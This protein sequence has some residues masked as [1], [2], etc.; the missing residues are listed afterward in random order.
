MC[1]SGA[2]WCARADA[3][4]DVPDLHVLD[5]VDD[6][7]DRLVLTVESDQ[8]EA[9]C[10]S[11]GVL[12]AS[13]GRRSRLLHDAPCFGRVT[14]VRWL[15]R[16]WRCREPLCPIGVFSETHQIAPPRSVL[17]VR[18]VRWATDALAHDD[19]T[20]SALAR[21]IGVLVSLVVYRRLQTAAFKSIQLAS[22]LAQVAR[23]GREVIDG[24]YTQPARLTNQTDDQDRAE[25]PAA[26]EDGWHEI[27][28]P[29]QPAIPQVIDV[30]RVLHTAE[31]AGTVI[32]LRVGSGETLSEGAV[33]AVCGGKTGPEL[34]QQVLKALTI[35]DER[36][37]E[38]D[39]AL[40]LGLLA[41]IALRALSSAV[42][43]PTTAV[44]AIDAIDGLLRV[45]A[46]RDL[47]I[48]QVA[49][50][51]GTIRVVLV[52]PTWHDCLAAALDDITSLPFL[53]P[54]VSR[55][56]RRLLDDLATI[57]TPDRRPELETY[58]RPILG[59]DEQVALDRRP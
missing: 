10:P 18:A 40:P 6:D 15:K 23:R 45:L 26:A 48:G 42:N 1:G 30:P 39:P 25:G 16:V 7:Q 49:G 35:G 34:D 5:V 33:I 59:K 21:H 3:I 4:F 37:F 46:T 57:T 11:C 22:T 20:V 9:G 47:D 58:R 31:R 12:A 27:L 8:V 51:D 38:Q 13:H 14:M 53:S 29:D 2:R 44:Q 50:K 32:K 19:T 28:W 17:T 43:D 56:I 52:L 55:R 24:L 41:D 54:S 36:T